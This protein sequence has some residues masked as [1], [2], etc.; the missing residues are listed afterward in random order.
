MLYL[1][2]LKFFEKE[3][4]I[5][6][7]SLF[8]KAEKNQD[9]ENDLL[10]VLIHGHYNDTFKQLSP[11]MFGDGREGLADQAQYDFFHSFRTSY[12]T[13]DNRQDFITS[14]DVDKHKAMKQYHIITQLELLIYL[15]FWESD[16]ILKQLY[17]LSSNLL[18]NKAYD[19][20][21]DMKSAGK[22]SLI[23]DLIIKASKNK[24]PKFYNYISTIYSRQIRNA[25]AHSQFWLS[26]DNLNFNNFD[27]QE[28]HM[29]KTLQIT[30]WEDIFHK[31]IQFYNFFIAKRN[32]LNKRFFVEA[33]D[34]HFGK[35]IRIVKNDG[36][37]QF[38]WLKCIPFPYRWQWYKSW[39]KTGIKT[40]H[41]L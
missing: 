40:F 17:N 19:W 37:I 18:N 22:K 1:D 3:A 38:E 8:T 31:T 41:I 5:A 39:A 27:P 6:V 34:K 20:H 23:E 28:G 24:A 36:T 10:L 21:K 15:K 2:R 25:A 16:Y 13:K 35:Q 4:E 33:E 7:G 9:H 14:L 32:E 12:I 26:G 30:E 11:Y 29:L